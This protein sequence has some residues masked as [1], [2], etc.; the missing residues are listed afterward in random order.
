MKHGDKCPHC[1]EQ[2][3]YAEECDAYFCKACDVWLEPKCHDEDC[4]TCNCRTAKPSEM[5]GEEA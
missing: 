1:G 2:V 5:Y 3:E 4:S